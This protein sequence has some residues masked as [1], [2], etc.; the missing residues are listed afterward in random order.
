MGRMN[1]GFR[2]TTIAVLTAIVRFK[3]RLVGGAA[4]GSA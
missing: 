3:S 2:V 4:G 1:Q